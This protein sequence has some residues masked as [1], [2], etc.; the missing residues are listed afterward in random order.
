MPDSAEAIADRRSSVRFA[1]IEQ[2][3]THV[4]IAE[5]LRRE[6]TLGLPLPGEALPPERELAAMF[7][8][9]RATVQRAVRVLESEGLVETR[10]GRGGGIFVIGP[11][12]ET[13]GRRR[14][15][16]RVRRNR[17]LI[18]EAVAYRLEVEPAA[19]SEAARARTPEDLVRLRQIVDR[20]VKTT[21]DALFTSLDASFHLAVASS[22]HNRF[23]AEAVERVRLSL[24]DAI[25]LLPE[26]P[27][28]QQRSLQEHQRIFA[29]LEAGDSG[30][31]RK[32]VLAHVGHTAQSVRALLRAL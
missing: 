27:L 30:A 31:A 8:V 13:V 4:Y 16:P 2:T 23:F 18:E 1:P 9:A 29:A 22:A 11:P 12:S 5:Q 19:A 6:I 3:R 24:N 32:A 17:G 25:L 28:W 21:D 14:L 20:A 7:G 10:R 15:I 26:S